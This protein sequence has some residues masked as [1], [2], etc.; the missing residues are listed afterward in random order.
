MV[1]AASLASGFGGGAPPAAAASGSRVAMA[2]GIG[3][4]LLSQLVAA[5]QM[6][7]DADSW[8]AR[9]QL[10]PLKVVGCEGVLGAAIMV[11]AETACW[12]CCSAPA[13]CFVLR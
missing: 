8:N 9:L 12:C 13:C 10:S 4:I 7:I 2:W 3:F 1:A 11:R 6:L 5:G